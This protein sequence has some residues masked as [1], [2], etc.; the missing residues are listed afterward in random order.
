MPIVEARVAE[1]QQQVDARRN[2]IIVPLEAAQ[3]PRSLGD[4]DFAFIK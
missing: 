4:T 2:L 1:K 3:L